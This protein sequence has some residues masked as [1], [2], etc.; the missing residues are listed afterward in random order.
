MYR[1]VLVLLLCFSWIELV[2]LP[3]S[4]PAAEGQTLEG[5]K[6]LLPTALRGRPAVLVLGF[7]KGSTQEARSWSRELHRAETSQ[8]RDDVYDLVML[9]RVPPLLRGLVQAQIRREVPPSLRSHFIALTSRESEWRALANVASADDIYI[10]VVDRFGKLRWETHG[11]PSQ[12][13][14]T[15]AIDAIDQAVGA[16][17]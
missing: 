15:A 17:Q 16:Q 3:T 9:E 10:L 1:L 4:L 6:V 12:Q 8:G 5:E 13:K 2:A 14:V 11:A 7:S